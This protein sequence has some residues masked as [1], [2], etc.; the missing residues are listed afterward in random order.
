MA[1]LYPESHRFFHAFCVSPQV[2]F[3]SKSA[4]ETIVLVLRAHP[5]TQLSWLINGLFLLIIVIFLNYVIPTVFTMNQIIFT[6]VFG[7]FFVFSYLWMNFILWFFNV[8][9]VT[10][11]RVLD[12]DITNILYRELSSTVLGKIED[13]T[14]KSAGYFGSLF[15]FG[16]LIIQT[17]GTDA[18]IE[19]LNIPNPAQANEIVNNLI[20]KH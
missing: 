15:N 14:S 13:V 5:I 6:N 8:G 1:T 4:D 2:T 20:I 18:N 10:N 12:L 16:N 19:F 9:I 17:A 11:K 3:D 7:L